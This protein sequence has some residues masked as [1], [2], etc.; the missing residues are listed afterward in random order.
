MKPINQK[1]IDKTSGDCFSAC[2]NSI[3][4]RDDVPN[5]NGDINDRRHWIIKANEWLKSFNYQVVFYKIGHSPT[6]LGYFIITVNSYVFEGGYH[7][8]VGYTDDNGVT[9]VVYNP[10]PQDPRGT[11]IPP[12]DWR[13]IYLLAH[14]FN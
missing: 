11:D 13:L 1:I 10:N 3:L 2:V 7:S 6:P 14:R 5:F 9:R 12:E 4:E 8:V